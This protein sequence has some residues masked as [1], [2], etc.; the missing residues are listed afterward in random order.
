M[1]PDQSVDVCK[2]V[3]SEV[4]M[5][6]ASGIEHGGNFRDSCAL[7]VFLLISKF[8][9]KRRVGPSDEVYVRPKLNAC[10]CG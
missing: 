2:R 1:V 10:Q 3:H 9:D 6:M 5:K 8:H 4:P 7:F